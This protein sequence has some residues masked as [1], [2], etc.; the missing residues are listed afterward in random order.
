MREARRLY[1]H[2]Q[3]KLYTHLDFQ[4]TGEA[5]LKEL[6]TDLLDLGLFSG[7]SF[8]SS[9]PE[10]AAL[11]DDK[12]ILK[13]YLKDLDKTAAQVLHLLGGPRRQGVFIIVDLPRFA[14]SYV[15]QA[16]NWVPKLPKGSVETQVKAALAYLRGEGSEVEFIYPPEGA[17]LQEW[18]QR[19]A[20]HY[21]VQLTGRALGYLCSASEGNLMS[22]DQC[23]KLFSI[24]H[25][26]AQIDLEELSHVLQSDSR[27]SGYELP[28]AV[29]NA[30]SL[31]AL[32]IIKSM[33][34]QSSSELEALGL[35]I[36]RLDQALKVL[37]R[38]RDEQID[39]LNPYSSEVSDFFRRE[40][41]M[42]LNLRKALLKA[43][44]FLPPEFLSYI[45]RELESAS[46]SYL[47]FDSKNACIHLQN[48]CMC[49]GNR[50][51]MQFEGL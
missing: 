20:A 19:R 47:Q 8:D 34:N 5:N 13:I 2:A 42:S 50:Q 17:A 40:R 3:L 23:L 41:V 4:S 10:E 7:F 46:R 6:Q 49:V 31:R 43:A 18:T 45:C 30:D 9:N 26:G 16:K 27:Y 33:L 29:F 12:L 51:I 21:Q 38:A 22:I 37:V 14:K 39:K 48:I 32:N 1:P 44:K 36:S 24:T 11:F 35:L 15:T 28:E 25:K